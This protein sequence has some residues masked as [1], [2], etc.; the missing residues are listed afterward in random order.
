MFAYPKKYKILSLINVLTSSTPGTRF[1]DPCRDPC[2][3]LNKAKPHKIA[4]YIVAAIL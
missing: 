3:Y 1:G 4:S 2:I